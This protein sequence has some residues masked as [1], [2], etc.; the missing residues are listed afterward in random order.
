MYL[1]SKTG[2]TTSIKPS[3]NSTGNANEP[4]EVRQIKTQNVSLRQLNVQFNDLQ[5]GLSKEA[6]NNT[7]IR[8]AIDEIKNEIQIKGNQF[9]NTIMDMQSDIELVK[10]I[11]LQLIKCITM[12]FDAR[13]DEIQVNGREITN[14]SQ[15]ECLCSSDDSMGNDG[16]I[17]LNDTYDGYVYDGLFGDTNHYTLN[18]YQPIVQKTNQLVSDV[19]TVE[20]NSMFNDIFDRIEELQVQ[21]R[22]L[23]VNVENMDLNCKTVDSKISIIDQQIHKISNGFIKHNR[24]MCSFI[25]DFQ[26]QNNNHY[27]HYDQGDGFNYQSNVGENVTNNA[28]VTGDDIIQIYPNG[29]E[30]FCSAEIDDGRFKSTNLEINYTRFIGVRITNICIINL[31]TF[32]K[33]FIETFNHFIGKGIA[34]NIVITKYKIV[35][36]IIMQLEAIVQLSTPLECQYINKFKFP[37]NWCFDVINQPVKHRFRK[38]FWK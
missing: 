10:N 18:Q 17:N 4:K 27:E 33:D 7:K 35:R 14:E 20:Q 37:S 11:N 15:G 36:G 13:N 38:F 28:M 29:S 16:Q 21:I 19:T 34:E 32:T 6:M 12:M 1:R 25:L 9:D 8:R 31:N 5:E 2:S 3:R 30:L 24:K 26:R 22:K 23:D